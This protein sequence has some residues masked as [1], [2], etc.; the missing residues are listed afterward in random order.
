M[1]SALD[2]ELGFDSLSRVE[3]ILRI[4]R[5]FA[6]SLSEQL[7]AHAETP[8]DLYEAVQA[9][10][11]SS[12]KISPV[13]EIS[14][15]TQEVV[16]GWPDKAETL[17]DAL[18]WHLAAHPDRVHVYLYGEGD[19]PEEITYGDLAAG[20]HAIAAGLQSKGLSPGN[21]VAIMLPTGKD[22]LNSFFGILLAG[23][24]PVPIYP[25]ARPSQLED[26]LN[27]HA[28]I[29]ENARTTLLITMSEARVVANLLR[30]QVETLAEV[31]TFE[32]LTIDARSFR[33]VPA[34]SGD[35]AFLQ[36]T[37]GSTGQPKGVV[38]THGNLLANIRA[39]GEA[40]QVD[41]RDVFVSWLPLYHDMGLIGA[42]LGSLYFAMP[43]VLMS[44][45]SFL[46]HPSRWLWSIH[47]H[48][49][50]LSAAPNFAYELCLT[51]ILDEDIEGLDLK[52][53]RLA[54][55]GA[56]PVS[57]N[58][59]KKFS[60][61]FGPFGFRQN[62]PAPVY[63]LAEAAVGLAFP[64]VGREPL[65]ERV[66]R[67]SL[68]SRGEARLAG[69]SDT[70]ALEFVAC[71]QPLPG[72]QLRVVDPAGRELPERREGRVQFQ[73]PSAT[74]GYF[75]NPEATQIL[76]EGDWLNTGDLGYIAAGDLYLTSRV[77]DLIIRGGRN[78][79]PYEV[80][81]A[82]GELPGI[83]KGCVAM[84]GSLDPA[85]GTER[86][87]VVAETRE[88]DAASLEGLREKIRSLAVDLL[89]MPPDEVVLAPPYTVLKTSSGKIRRTAVK[90]L[91][92]NGEIG[93]QARAVWLQFTRLMLSSLGPRLKRLNR[94]LMDRGYALYAH[95]LFWLLAPLVWLSVVISPEGKSAWRLMRGGA[96]LLFRLAGIPFE[97]EGLEQLPQDGSIVLVA[98]HASY[99]DGVALVAALPVQFGFVAKQELEQQFVSRQFLSKIGAVFV[100]RF[101]R[102]RGVEDA[103]RI[104]WM[105]H[106]GESMLYFPEGTFRRA[107]GLLPFH[108]GAFSAA[109]EAKVPVVPVTIRGMRSILRDQEWFPRRG[110]V[111]IT[112]EQAIAADNTEWSGAVK[113][114]DGVRESILKHLGEPDVAGERSLV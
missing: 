102:K 3:L 52:S 51:K 61:R 96:R 63:G 60:A 90:A 1:D 78:I 38:L 9:A 16:E 85:S 77:K 99:L 20:A 36:Y 44:P 106:Q 109:A 21:T 37:S 25:P 56:E 89:G 62:S 113:L 76:L 23:G 7:L 58:T 65:I 26:H 55:N 88:T 100:E 43:M 114:R 82:T 33:P 68:L 73:G 59:L 84:F 74:S 69:V 107:P 92:E 5:A 64:P 42:W 32:E 110:K 111:R 103:R 72:Y 28:R 40:I 104:T 4:E 81:E 19:S 14:P 112:V 53:W 22:Y 71:G 86:V 13:Q 80:E 49:A 66:Q 41:S 31:V 101:D 15:V 39:M 54:F 94:Y 79:Y 45:L 105:L 27:R 75:Q 35:I 91:Y 70:D 97:V 47:H 87:V 34:E 46:A 95:A 29:L 24:I 17:V 98:N 11:P 12:A 48:R 8:R 30:A 50:T 6:V 93:R 67:D 83:R 57:P 2:R 10:G 108:M 18:D